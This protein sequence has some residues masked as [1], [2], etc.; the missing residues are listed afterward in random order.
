MRKK[1]QACSFKIKV[2]YKDVQNFMK[3]CTFFVLELPNY[4]NFI[5]KI[6]KFFL[7]DKF[8]QNK[9]KKYVIIYIKGMLK[10]N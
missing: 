4:I 8:Q 10:F 7:F 1:G 5:K 3:F 2:E 9:V 6:K